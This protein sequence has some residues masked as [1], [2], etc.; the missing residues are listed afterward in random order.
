MIKNVLFVILLLIGAGFV[1]KVLLIA[2]AKIGMMISFGATV[3]VIGLVAI[4][5]FL[6]LFRSRPKKSDGQGNS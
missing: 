4:I 2:M 6:L 3:G 5:L 1:G